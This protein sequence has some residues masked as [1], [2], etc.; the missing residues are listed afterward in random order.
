M[1]ISTPLDPL[2][3]TLATFTTEAHLVSQLHI[4]YDVRPKPRNPPRCRL[5]WSALESPGAF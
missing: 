5:L 2:L 4:L 1:Q 3:S